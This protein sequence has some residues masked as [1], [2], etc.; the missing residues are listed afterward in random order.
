M[1]IENITYIRLKD[2]REV[3]APEG[4]DS[5]NPD[6]AVIAKLEAQNATKAEDSSTE[7]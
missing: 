6:L 7:S 5:R 1:T 3:P 2:G 4:F